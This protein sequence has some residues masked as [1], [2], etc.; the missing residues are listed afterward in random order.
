MPPQNVEA[1][2]AVLAA[3][4]LGDAR[5]IDEALDAGLKTE[6][7]YRVANGLI[8]DALID[9]WRSDTPIDAVSLKNK[10]VEWKVYEEVGGTAYIMALGDVVAT[11]ANV[12]YHAR[13]VI[14]KSQRRELIKAA[15]EAIGRAY[16]DERHI[17]EILSDV[18]ESFRPVGRDEGAEGSI[19]DQVAEALGIMENPPEY[20][21][22]GF[23]NIDFY[24]EGLRPGD[25]VVIGGLQ[26]E[27]K[28]SFL[29]SG[30]LGMAGSGIPS[31]LF[32][33]EM[34]PLHI[35]QRAISALSGVDGRKIKAGFSSMSREEKEKVRDAGVLLSNMPI[36]FGHVRGLNTSLL[37]ARVKRR[38]RRYGL[39]VVAV[40]YL[41]KIRGEKSFVND[42]R[43]VAERIAALKTIAIEQHVVMLVTAQFNREIRHRM[44]K[45]PRISDFKGSSAIESE[46]DV[47][48]LLYMQD[49]DRESDKNSIVPVEV[50]VGK[51]RGNRTGTAQMMFRK[52]TTR[53]YDAATHR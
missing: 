3:M 28:T 1:E 20:I 15:T 2:Q 11:T 52:E 24:L 12:A 35:T 51:N 33:F 19:A 36:H 31:A 44:D 37:A 22:T 48:L 23:S 10:L 42:E 43:D 45:K 27:G 4:L 16:D 53:Y 26:G 8:F 40:D 14:E 29:L 30:C 46:A 9:L 38:K 49:Q 13:I 5:T 50:I 34:E 47:I 6:D 17:G 32:N 25:M 41:G 21:Y 18:E 39:D 7:F